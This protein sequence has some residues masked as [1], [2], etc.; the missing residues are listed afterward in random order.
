VRRAEGKSG[1][2]IRLHVQTATGK[3]IIAESDILVATGRRP[4]RQAAYDSVQYLPGV[5]GVTNDIT[6]KPSLQPCS[7]KDAIE[8]ALKRD[9]EI[10]ADLVSVQ[11]DGGKVS[12]SGSVRS[13]AERDEAGCAAWSAPAVT[14]VENDLTVS[15]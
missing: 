4:T 11:A 15:Y 1:E 10:D 14:D 12:R 13:W 2:A 7:V 9:A 6:I 5:I 8:K 3:Q